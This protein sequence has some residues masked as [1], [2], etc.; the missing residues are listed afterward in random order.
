MSLCGAL[1]IVLI[2]AFR[3]KGNWDIL[4][5]CQEFIHWPVQD[6]FR[7]PPITSYSCNLQYCSFLLRRGGLTGYQG[8]SWGPVGG[9]SGCMNVR[10]WPQKK[11]FCAQTIFGR[12]WVT[13][14][15]QNFKKRLKMSKNRVQKWKNVR[16]SHSFIH[17]RL[18]ICQKNIWV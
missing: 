5:R 17:R 3:N 6:R 12:S 14:V 8:Y 16:R 7:W 2:H 10:V 13:I 9:W 18:K 11:S 15:H 4:I 1:F